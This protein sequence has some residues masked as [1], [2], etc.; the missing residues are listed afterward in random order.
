MKNSKR[1]LASDPA[2]ASGQ[3]Q[4]PGQKRMMARRLDRKE[5]GTTV[6]RTLGAVA[7]D[8]VVGP[9]RD[10]RVAVTGVEDR[11]TAQG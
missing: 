10:P 3:A 7:Q 4:A 6:V 5:M 11:D 8:A 9:W 1:G 2:P